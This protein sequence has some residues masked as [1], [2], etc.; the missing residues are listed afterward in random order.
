MGPARAGALAEERVGEVAEGTQHDS[1]GQEN[2]RTTGWFGI[3]LQIDD[4]YPMHLGACAY[5]HA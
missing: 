4:G 1:V 3:W 5:S 2:S